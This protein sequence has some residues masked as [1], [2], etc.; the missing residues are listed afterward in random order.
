[1]KN[2]SIIEFNEESL[3]ANSIDIINLA[4]SEGLFSHA[5][6]VQVRLKD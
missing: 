6:S 3:K 2:T 1:M 5:N 4:K